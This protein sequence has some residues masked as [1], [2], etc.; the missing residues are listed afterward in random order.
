MIAALQEGRPGRL[1]TPKLRPHD[2]RLAEMIASGMSNAAIARE[3]GV[4]R[5]TIAKEVSRLTIKLGISCGLRAWMKRQGMM[6]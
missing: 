5:G 2:V 4:Q 3:R 1:T 6:R